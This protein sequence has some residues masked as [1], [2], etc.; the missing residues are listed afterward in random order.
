VSGDLAKNPPAVP[1]TSSIPHSSRSSGAPSPTPAAAPPPSDASPSLRHHNPRLR[2]RHTPLPFRGH[3]PPVLPPF[4]VCRQ[5]RPASDLESKVTEAYRI[6]PT[7]RL[8][9]AYD[10]RCGAP[11][12]A[13]SRRASPLADPIATRAHLVSVPPAGTWRSTR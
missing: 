13:C 7:P 12:T 5:G 4:L 8:S 1:T 2:R 3:P 10:E 9:F 11:L 6:P